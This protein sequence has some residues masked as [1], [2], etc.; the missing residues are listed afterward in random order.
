M[1]SEVPMPRPNPEGR[2]NPSWVSSNQVGALTLIECEGSSVQGALIADAVEPGLRMLAAAR[3]QGFMGL[4]SNGLLD[5]LETGL[6]GCRRTGLVAL[7]LE[8]I[9]GFDLCIVDG[10]GEFG[11]F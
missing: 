4:E 8:D 2:H 3:V 7:L 5:A 9:A 11:V 6:V 1:S 10:V